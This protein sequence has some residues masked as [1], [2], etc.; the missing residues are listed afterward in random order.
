[1]RWHLGHALAVGLWRVAALGWWA[2]ALV[3]QGG[4][5][6]VWAWL[7]RLCNGTLFGT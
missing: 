1:V 2:C 6:R 4:V 7:C 3:W 5:D